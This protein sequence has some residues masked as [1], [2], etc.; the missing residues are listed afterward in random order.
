[1]HIH[2]S[3]YD[4]NFAN[5][6]TSSFFSQDDM[7]WKY[8]IELFHSSETGTTFCTFHSMHSG[9][10][11][12][13]SEHMASYLRLTYPVK[14]SRIKLLYFNY[15]CSRIFSWLMHHRSSVYTI[16]YRYVYGP[17]LCVSF[18]EIDFHF[19]DKYKRFVVDILVEINY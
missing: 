1:M 14:D 5:G 4:R 3:N 18:L 16:Y 9:I 10:N 12:F 15:S 2:S 19:Q 13:I 8:L 17:M 11:S 7:T 6:Q